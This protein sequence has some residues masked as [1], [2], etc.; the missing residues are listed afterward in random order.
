[1]TTIETISW[2]KTLNHIKQERHDLHRTN[3]QK[4]QMYCTYFVREDNSKWNVCTNRNVKDFNVL[5]E[6]VFLNDNIFRKIKLIH[7]F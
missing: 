3:L 1:M 4:V 6:N 2:S 7:S 5:R